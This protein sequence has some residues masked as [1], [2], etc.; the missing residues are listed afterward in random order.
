M[1]EEIRHFHSLDDFPID[2][3]TEIQKVNKVCG[4]LD[5]RKE[6]GG[7]LYVIQ[8][9][10][11]VCKIGITAGDPEKRLREINHGSWMDYE[12]KYISFKL[13]PSMYES[14]L[15]RYFKK[16]RIRG[17]W[18]SLSPQEIYYYSRHK[19]YGIDWMRYEH[20]KE[21]GIFEDHLKKTKTRSVA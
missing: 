16:F 11:Q 15:H 5:W 8:G 9:T 6:A 13:V 18:F 20:A 14:V 17:E 21:L 4:A 12:I 2:L 3:W 19:Y 7:F 1:H 10:P